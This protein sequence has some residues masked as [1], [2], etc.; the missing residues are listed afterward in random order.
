HAERT[1]SVEDSVVAREV[2]DIVDLGRFEDGSF[3]AVVCYGGPL[4][5]GLG[6][7][8]RALAGLLR[9]TE[10]G[11]HVLLSVISVLLA[12]RAFFSY[13]PKLIEDVG[14]SR[15]VED[16]FATGDLASDVNDGHVC[17]L[18][19]WSDLE[20]LVARHPCSI[21]AA[22]AANFLSVGNE[23]WDDRFLELEIE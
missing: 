18:Y 7:V 23:A 9:V 10:T 5:Y 8:D 2:L 15:A 20:R 19:R 12:R 3:D 22:S 16:I 21:V 4:S 11:G 14:W 13:C 6:E 17:R 1:S